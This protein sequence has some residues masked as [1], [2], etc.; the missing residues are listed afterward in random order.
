GAFTIH[1]DHDE[2]RPFDGDL[3]FFGKI[4]AALPID[5]EL[6][7]LIALGHA[8]GLVYEALLRSKFN[9]VAGTFCGCQ[10]FLNVYKTWLYH[11]SNHTFLLIDELRNRLRQLHIFVPRNVESDQMQRQ[12]N[13]ITQQ[14]NFLNFKIIIAG[15][16][17]LDYYIRE[18]IESETVD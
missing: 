7:R 4:M 13:P 16:F 11:E 3:T 10:A 1:M 18:P 5:I 15:A 6:S 2:I 8:F 17:Y 9:F 14:Q 12:R